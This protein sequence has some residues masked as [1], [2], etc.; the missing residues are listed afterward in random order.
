LDE[1]KFGLILE[2]GGLFDFF[3][4]GFFSQVIKKIILN[5]RGYFLGIL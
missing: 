5:L 1:S 2:F 4:A 3:G